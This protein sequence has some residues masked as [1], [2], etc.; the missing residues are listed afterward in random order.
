MKTLA[1]FKIEEG[2]S[3][4]DLLQGK[5]RRYAT[6]NN[7]SVIVATECDLAKPLFVFHNE[8]KNLH[9][10]CNSEGA[11]VVASI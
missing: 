11:K 8:E 4:I 3:Q 9:V 6:V 1:Q 10:I 7:K 2:V 5:G